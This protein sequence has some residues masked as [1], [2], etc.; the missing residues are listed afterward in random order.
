MPM[1]RLLCLVF[2]LL[3]AG[4]SGKTA[5]GALEAAPA[6][7]AQQ[8]DKSL[9]YQHSV[10]IDTEEGRV[11][12]LLERLVAACGADRENSC[13]LLKSS[14]EGGRNHEASLRVRA[15]PAGIGKL[16]ALA[17]SAGE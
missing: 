10:T 2:V 17:S 14:L 4:C 15:K 8:R 9:A 1:T 11:Q 12:P 5:S 13:T 3:L 6:T 7:S 16:L